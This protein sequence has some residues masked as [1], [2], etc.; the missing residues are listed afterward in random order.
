MSDRRLFFGSTRHPQS[1]EYPMAAGYIQDDM[2]VLDVGCGVGVGTSIIAASV[3]DVVG[4]D[5]AM[6]GLLEKGYTIVSYGSY[7]QLSKPSFVACRWEEYVPDRIFDVIFAVEVIEHLV[8]PREFVKWLSGHG[9]HTFM[10]TPM[11][12]VTGPTHNS[13]HV[14]EY[15]HKDLIELVQ[16]FFDVVDVVYQ[17]GDLRITDEA[18]PMGCSSNQEHIVQMLWMKS[19]L[20]TKGEKK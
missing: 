16:P 14:V 9:Y 6:K 17:H 15:S 10:T 19:K 5:P 13:V 2:S 12:D 20:Q 8:N 1:Y 7:K 3:K 11:V 18:V 4:V